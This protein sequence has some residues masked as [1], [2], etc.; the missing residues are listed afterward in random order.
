MRAANFNLT[1]YFCRHR[2]PRADGGRQW[3]IKRG[4]KPRI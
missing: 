4:R 1:E 2:N 3:R